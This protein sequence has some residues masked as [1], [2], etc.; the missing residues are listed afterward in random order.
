[1]SLLPSDFQQQLKNCLQNPHQVTVYIHV[2]PDSYYKAFVLRLHT[3]L[4]CFIPVMHFQW[5]T[6]CLHWET[7]VGHTVDWW[8]VSSHGTTMTWWRSINQSIKPINLGTNALCLL[9]LK[10]I[11]RNKK[12]SN[13][14]ILNILWNTKFY[15]VH[16]RAQVDICT[17]FLRYCIHK[18]STD[19]Q[20]KYLWGKNSDGEA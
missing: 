5:E 6:C 12:N 11:D 18:N 10:M 20:P 8:S 17:I 2:C 16:L 7:I 9:M 1:M 13:D 14:L 19:G 15:L 4:T 3:I